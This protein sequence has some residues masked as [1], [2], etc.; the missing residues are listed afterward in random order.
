MVVSPI[1][2]AFNVKGV[3]SLN[4]DGLTAAQIFNGQIN[5]WNDGAIALQN[6]GV[7]AAQ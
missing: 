2:I 5:M 1:A 3:T 7:T 4:L 6:L